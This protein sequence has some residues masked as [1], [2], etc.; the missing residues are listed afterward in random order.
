[1]KA[2]AAVLTLEGV[3][4]Q[5]I[6]KDVEGILKTIESD[7]PDL[8]NGKEYSGRKLSDNFVQAAQKFY[9]LSK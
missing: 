9:K 8:K 4:T 2:I 3:Q 7:V 6:E 5:Y 1:M